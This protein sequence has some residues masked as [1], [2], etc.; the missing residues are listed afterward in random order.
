M[1]SRVSGSPTWRVRASG[2]T[3]PSPASTSCC[4]VRR[5]S[6]S[7]VAA[8]PSRIYEEATSTTSQCRA[9]TMRWSPYSRSSTP[10]EAT[11]S[12]PPGPTS[13]LCSKRPSSS[14]GEL[15]RG[16]RCHSSRRHGRS[17]TAAALHPSQALRV[18]SSSKSFRRRSRT[19]LR[20]T[21]ARCWSRTTLNGV[22]IDV[23]AERLNTTRGALYKTL[24]DARQKLR[25]C[26]AN[27]GMTIGE[28]GKEDA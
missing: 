9:P 1:R 14:A 5:A 25:T 7:I 13:S 15:G 28:K 2:T 23:L 11:A 22:P 6:R 18:V 3:R 27:R 10:T 21:S 20:R 26:L 8:P 12:S 4:S 16:V 24:H 19:S 17:F